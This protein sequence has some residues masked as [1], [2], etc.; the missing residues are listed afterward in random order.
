[1]ASRKEGNAFIPASAI[2]KHVIAIIGSESLSGMVKVFA[3]STARISK[4]ERGSR[5]KS[6][7]CQDVPFR[8]R[9]VQN[10]VHRIPMKNSMRKTQRGIF[11][12]H[13]RH[14]HHCKRYEKTGISSYHSSCFLHEVHRLLPVKNDRF[15]FFSRSTPEKLPK[16]D[17]MRKNPT[18]TMNI[19]ELL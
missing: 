16:H 11:S 5:K 17:H 18:I 7:S 13:F 12:P 14:F 2:I 4:N 3:S 9:Y 8:K 15:I 1:M 10:S 6:V 19:I